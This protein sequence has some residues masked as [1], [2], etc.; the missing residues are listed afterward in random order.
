MTTIPTY[1]LN[2]GNTIPAIGFGTFRLSGERGV[3]SIVSALHLGYRLLDAAFIYENEGSVGE[4]VRRCGIPRDE[5]LISSKLPGRH[6]VYKQ[7][8]RI[9]EEQLFRFGLDHFD[10]YLIHWPIP[11]LE[12]Y[13]QAWQA[14][15]DAKAAG[16][17]RTIGVSNFLPE[18]LD[19]IIA[20][21]GVTPSL[22]QIERHPWWPSDDL[23][24]ANVERGIQ[25]EAWS[26]LGR[27]TDLREEPILAKIAARHGRT[28]SQILLRLQVQAGVIPLPKATSPERQAENLQV[29]DFELTA[30]DLAEIATMA[31]EDGRITNADPMTF[32][33]M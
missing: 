11:R 21:T 27:M 2:D 7:A 17:I 13:P 30:E 33:Q 23:L 3:T 16:L 31:R 26:P 1:Q 4:A 29:F 19:R 5:I 8:R 24:A 12:L 9:I 6:H 14:L 18:H 25:V 22:N 32:E 10:V 28:P 20:E 15:I